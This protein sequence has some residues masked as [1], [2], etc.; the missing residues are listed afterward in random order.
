MFLMNC[1]QEI[2]YDR[3][4]CMHRFWMMPSVVLKKLVMGTFDKGFVDRRTADS[5]DFVVESVSSRSTNVETTNLKV[6]NRSSF[7]QVDILFCLVDSWRH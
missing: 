7:L 6:D 1:L 4:L 2:Q 3:V 5:I